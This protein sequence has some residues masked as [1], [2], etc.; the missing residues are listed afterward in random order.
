MVSNRDQT[1]RISRRL[2][3]LSREFFEDFY[4]KQA[5][6]GHHPHPLEASAALGRIFNEISEED[7]WLPQPPDRPEVPAEVFDPV[8]SRFP[9]ESYLEAV[10]AWYRHTP[11]LEIKKGKPGRKPNEQLAETIWKLQTAGNSS[12]KIQKDLEAA[13]V[14]LSIEGVESYLKKRRRPH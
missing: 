6:A 8:I 4:A 14:V 13:G 2:R 5:K 10:E 9:Q 3:Q 1:K 12:R 7:G 11:G